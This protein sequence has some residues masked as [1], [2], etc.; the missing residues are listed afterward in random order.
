MTFGIYDR[1]AL[2]S[3]FAACINGEISIFGSYYKEALGSPLLYA[4]MARSRFS[5]YI[6]EKHCARRCNMYQRRHRDFRYT[7]YIHVFVLYSH[8]GYRISSKKLNG[9]Q[10]L[11]SM[12]L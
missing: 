7:L 1:E 10:A 9:H 11:E 12:S 4:T 6:I 2:C 3:L 8:Y 5:V